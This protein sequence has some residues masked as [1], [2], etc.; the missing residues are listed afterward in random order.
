MKEKKK[1]LMID[2]DEINNYIAEEWV[3]T[4]YQNVASLIVFSDAE[5]AVAH[6]R[7]CPEQDFPDLIMCDLKMPGFDGFE[8][9]EQY[10]KEFYHQH[11]DTKIVI[12]SSS[13]R[14]DDIK[15]SKEYISVVDFV[16]K[17]SIQDSFKHIF[18]EYF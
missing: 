15:K 13:I 5:E 6:L 8:F 18:T 14:K 10:E 4:N 11:Q 12:L 9:I 17:L 1:I 3:N 16:P 7:T 2:D